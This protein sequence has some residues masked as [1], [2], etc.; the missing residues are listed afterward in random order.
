MAKTRSQTNKNKP[1]ASA[2]KKSVAS[3][4]AKPVAKP[5]SKPGPKPKSVRFSFSGDTETEINK[6]ET[7]HVDRKSRSTRRDNSFGR[8]D[9]HRSPSPRRSYDGRDFGFPYGVPSPVGVP[10]LGYGHSFD[11]RYSLPPYGFFN[12][13][14]IPVG[15]D[16][17]LH[18]RGQ[19]FNYRKQGKRRHE[20]DSSSDGE[21]TG[22]QQPIVMPAK[23][24]ARSKS[25]KL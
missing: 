17:N 1:S 20:S 4:N 23:R 21:I 11:W 9:H 12:Y 2:E 13:P 7:A 10:G 15:F 18:G 3:N 22:S 25:C 5:R 16:P 24:I 19:V 8:G 6:R 14:N